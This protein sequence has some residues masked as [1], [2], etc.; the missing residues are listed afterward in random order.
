VEPG[1]H[2]GGQGAADAL[3]DEGADD[4]KKCLCRCSFIGALVSL[5]DRGAVRLCDPVSYYRIALASED[6]QRRLG[7][8]L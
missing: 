5:N 2:I 6:R 3:G 8:P 7:V 1:R 4:P